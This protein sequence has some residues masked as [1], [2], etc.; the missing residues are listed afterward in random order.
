M[1]IDHL[2]VPVVWNIILAII[3]HCT[4][5]SILVLILLCIKYLFSIM[6]MIWEEHYYSQDI[7]CYLFKYEKCRYI[8]YH[9]IVNENTCIYL[10]V[11]KYPS[12]NCKSLSKFDFHIML[13]TIYFDKKSKKERYLEDD[14][15]KSKKKHLKFQ[16]DHPL[17]QI[18]REQLLSI[19]AL[20]YKFCQWLLINYFEN[21]NFLLI[22][23]YQE[24][25]NYKFVMDCRMKTHAIIKLEHQKRFF[26]SICEDEL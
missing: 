9:G 25:W 20:T 6:E 14:E 18:L 17:H 24:N 5:F 10:I 19:S 3:S 12:K 11:E 1:I 26:L 15:T 2:S 8:F 13:Y 23:L 7:I 21:S 22:I 4:F 16:V